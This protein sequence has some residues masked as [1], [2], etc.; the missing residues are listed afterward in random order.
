MLLETKLYKEMILG[1]C[2]LKEADIS[3][4]I[5]EVLTSKFL[6]DLMTR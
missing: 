3:D 4:V 1:I 2:C 6:T 5:S